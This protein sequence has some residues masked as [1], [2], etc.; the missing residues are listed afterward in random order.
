M[1]EDPYRPPE[2]TPVATDQEL[3]E[4]PECGA[5][6][7]QGKVR[8]NLWWLPEKPTPWD[9]FAGGRRVFGHQAFTITLGQPKRAA[10]R[11]SNCH[12]ILVRPEK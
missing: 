7:E 6:L 11:C 10:L 5:L 4:C 12:L 9:Y 8:G 3:R 1:S 2:E